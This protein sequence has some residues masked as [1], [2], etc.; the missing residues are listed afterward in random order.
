MKIK[1]FT[2][3]IAILTIFAVSSL[4]AQTPNADKVTKFKNYTSQTEFNQFL[5]KYK[6]K[7]S[8]DFV[9]T[10]HRIIKDVMPLVYLKIDF[11][12]SLKNINLAVYET[13]G[14]L[15]T[16]MWLDS[17]YIDRLEDMEVP[18]M[19]S[20]N[21]KADYWFIMTSENEKY[22]AMRKVTVQ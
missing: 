21:S 12:F 22:V 2:T 5:D 9:I 17:E 1:I 16:S 20:K 15:V 19:L 4:T 11:T 8:K 6:S 10:G 7:Q 3:L 14:T 13:N 18:V